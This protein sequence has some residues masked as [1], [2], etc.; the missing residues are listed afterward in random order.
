MG[1][2]KK[3]RKKYS[4]P[5]HPWRSDQLSQELYLIGSY[6]LR[7]KRELWK[8]RTTLSNIRK[9]TR[10]LLAESPEIR[11]KKENEFL[12]SLNRRGIVGS[13]ASLDDV[14]VL[15]VENILERR[16]QTT[17]WK[18]GI[19]LSPYQSR[20]MITHGHIMIGGKVVTR[21]GYMIRSDEEKDIRLSEG[22]PL[23]EQVKST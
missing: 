6:G 2:P 3:P 11:A 22:S 16:L 1:D 15:T 5:K 9:Q 14:L 18:K 21:P 19:A 20:Q 8:A 4:A 10:T 23:R 17:V 12:S 7:N 13:K